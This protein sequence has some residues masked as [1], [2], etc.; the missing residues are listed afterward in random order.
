[1]REWGVTSIY[2]PKNAIGY[3]EAAWLNTKRYVP[4]YEHRPRTK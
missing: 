4:P 1:M 2:L 3:S